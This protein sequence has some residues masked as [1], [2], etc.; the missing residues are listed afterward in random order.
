MNTKYES[1]EIHLADRFPS[2][3]RYQMTFQEIEKVLGTSLPKSAYIHRPWWGNQV[4]TSNRP[5]AKSWLSAG[6]KVHEVSQQ[7]NSGAVTFVKSGL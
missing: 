1:L 2:E 7:D 4:N 6:F 5:Q 3:E